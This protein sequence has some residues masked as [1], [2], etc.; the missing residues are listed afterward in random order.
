MT[1]IQFTAPEYQKD[2][3]FTDVP[4]EFNGS[5]EKGWDI[6]RQGSVIRTIGPG[7]TPVKSR[8]CGVCSTDLARKF[9]PYPLPDLIGHEVVGEKDGRSVV[10]EINASHLARGLTDD[11]CPY[12]GS[13]IDTQCPHRITLGIDRLPGG[14]SPFFLAPVNAVINVP[15]NISPEAASLTEPFAAALQGVEATWP[16]AGQKVAVLGPRRLGSL[17]IAAL[18]GYR[19]REKTN[20]E[21]TGIA[22]HDHLLQLCLDMG[23]DRTLDLRKTPAEKLD[24][25][26]DI[27]FDTTGS[28]E[29]FE[30]ALRAAKHVVHLKSTNGQTVQGLEYLTD[31]VVEEI[32]LLS[33]EQE[34]LDFTW[35]SEKSIRANANV[36]VSPNV[37]K[38]AV[39][40]AISWKNQTFHQMEALEA[41]SRIQTDPAFLK[42]SPLPRFDLAIVTSLAEADSVIRP[43]KGEEFSI[44]RPRGAILLLAGKEEKNLLTESLARGVAIHTSRCGNFHKALS[45]LS[46]NP[47][48]A[49]SFEKNMITHRYDLAHIREAFEKAASSDSI[50]VLVE[51]GHA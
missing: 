40:R 32:A 36:Y 20:F 14:F 39:D 18:S 46:A 16:K 33:Y 9:L 7:F 31:M 12:C 51:T 29:G 47:Q 10:V 38:D 34:Y 2:G 48:I 21:I 42:S 28:P 27:V 6:S 44:L 13:G 4:Y 45:I 37:S 35:P 50:K 43:V 11:S 15:A 3:S 25:I 41:R 1:Q 5:E 19:I 49:K 17:I 24:S 26:F 30:T 22:R 23:A 8:Y